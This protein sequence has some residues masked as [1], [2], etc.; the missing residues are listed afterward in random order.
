MALPSS[1]PIS[2]T[3]IQGTMGGT[4]PTSL[5]EYYRGGTYVPNITQNNSIPLSG[6]ISIGDFYDAVGDTSTNLSLT[7][8]F[9]A[10]DF[11]GDSSYY[12]YTSSGISTLLAFIDTP[13][14]SLSPSSYS[15][16]PGTVNIDGLVTNVSFGGL[17]MW[18][19]TNINSDLTFYEFTVNSSTYTRSSSTFTANVNYANGDPSPWSTWVWSSSPSTPGFSTTGSY[20]L[21]IRNYS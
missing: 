7:V 6:A 12:G 18:A 9:D 21:T 4:A 1:G 13:L 11:K 16:V 3:D 20:T 2:L 14:G 15:S 10:A 17:T 19:N 8:G 5:S